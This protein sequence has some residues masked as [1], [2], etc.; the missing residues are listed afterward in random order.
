MRFTNASVAEACMC[1]LQAIQEPEAKP[2]AKRR[3]KTAAG[4]G[5]KEADGPKGKVSACMAL[6][7]P[8]NAATRQANQQ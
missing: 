2:E 7:R 1:C 4:K 8:T 3:R 5:S 6:Q